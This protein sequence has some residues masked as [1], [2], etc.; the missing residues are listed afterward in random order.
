MKSVHRRMHRKRLNLKTVHRRM[1]RKRWNL[2]KWEEPAKE[3]KTRIISE[4]N[5]DTVSEELPKMLK[6][7]GN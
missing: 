3:T 5:I 2:K 6:S 4:N 7:I 1:H